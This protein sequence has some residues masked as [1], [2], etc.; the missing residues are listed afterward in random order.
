MSFFRR[1]ILARE[2][3]IA[4]LLIALIAQVL[5]VGQP[6]RAAAPGLEAAFVLCLPSGEGQP[7]DGSGT[8][9][10]MACCT[11]CLNNLRVLAVDD[12]GALVPTPPTGGFVRVAWD[13]PP[14]VS[15]GLRLAASVQP[16]GPPAPTL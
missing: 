6:A 14:Q 12:A 16:R 7:A 9:H 15:G 2:A 13:M 3:T 4:A 8:T 5:A 1:M 10:D 11:P